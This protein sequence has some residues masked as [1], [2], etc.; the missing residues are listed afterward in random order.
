[1]MKGKDFL[2][3]FRIWLFMTIIVFITLDIALS[4][5]T[6]KIQPKQPTLDP[7]AL[8]QYEEL[9]ASLNRAIT[10][11]K[12]LSEELAKKKEEISRLEASHL[13]E[14]NAVRLQL[15]AFG[16]LLS[17]SGSSLEDLEKAQASLKQ[18]LESTSAKLKELSG[19][20]DDLESRRKI[21]YEQKSINE[22]QIENIKDQASIHPI[23][24]TV[25]NQLKEIN[26]LILQ[27]EKHLEVLHGKIEKMIS[28][29]SQIQEEASLISQKMEIR[30]GERKKEELFRRSKNPLTLLGIKGIRGDV[31]QLGSLVRHLFTVDFWTEHIGSLW[32]RGGVLLITSIL[33]FVI[34]EWILVWVRKM[35]ISYLTD[36]AKPRKGWFWIGV[37]LLVWSLPLMGATVFVYGYGLARNLY[38]TFSPI[39]LLVFL[40]LLWLFFSWIIN[41]LKL[42]RERI[43]GDFGNL[44]IHR[45]RVSASGARWTLFVYLFLQ[46]FLG[47]NSSLLLVYRFFL[48]IILLGW[49]IGFSRIIKRYEFYGREAPRSIWLRGLVRLIIVWLYGVSVVGIL[50]ELAGY[51]SLVVL[52]YLGWGRTLVVGLWLFVLFMILR[53]WEEVADRDFEH[54]EEG[55][56]VTK[57]SFEWLMVRFL[58]VAWG[59]I[60]IVG[61]L[62]AWGATQ[63]VIVAFFK[64]LNTPLP[65]GGFTFRLSGLFYCALILAVTHVGVKLLKHFLRNRVL[66]NSG[67]E[68]GLQESIT[69]IGGYILWFFGALAALNALGFSGTS[70]AV[71]FGAL[72]VGL[73][74]GLQ[75]IFNN[76]IS[77][78]IL[79]F[80]RPIQVGDA[81][82]VDGVWGEVKKINFRST[83][84]QTWDNASLIIPNSEFISGRVT[85][86]SF[87]DLRVRSNIDI[88]V[89]YGSDIELVRKTLLE[90]AEN[91]PNV[92]KSPQPSVLF[93]N[94]G[95]SALIFR[96]RVWT[97]VNLKLQVETDIRFE[98]YRLF[99]ERKIEI[100]FPQRD[101]RVRIE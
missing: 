82:E 35:G 31:E 3:G 11:E 47:R 49:V 17:L 86:W 23:V 98:I 96:L 63:A 5:E 19:H 84:I 99:K 51:S 67:L 40:L 83:I 30:I 4:V 43:S 100:P 10:N 74:F 32:N 41:F 81:I 6:R 8:A 33:V 46:E 28:E 80:E 52:W 1:M 75:N 89:A 45:L 95:D 93:L 66:R 16:N 21:L 58:W 12:A 34:V 59:L 91:H 24:R 27:R 29:W 77:G 101:V 70:I 73:G 56:S 97:M 78:L 25:L 88:G 61:L 87:K 60:G 69:T 14:I 90:I 2:S 44:I 79:L 72:G 20:K 68:V 38:D 50:L 92:L 37:K 39:R 71:A 48:E 42:I 36:S 64:L 62:I 15:S 26:Q 85:N 57:G 76:F 13:Q 54:I 18:I 9:S 22:S 94:F 55:V 53:E 7:A 65:I